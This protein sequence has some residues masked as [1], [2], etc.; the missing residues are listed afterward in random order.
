VVSGEKPSADFDF[1]LNAYCFSRIE[2]ERSKKGMVNLGQTVDEIVR[3]RSTVPE[4]R[5]LLVGISGIDGSGKGYV[6][7][8][9]EAR[10][11]QCAI[12][13]ANINVDGWLNLPE[14]RFDLRSLAQN[15]YE[16]AIRFDEFFTELVIPLRDRRSMHLT[17]NYA[18][19]TAKTY[20]QHI[21]DF[22]N[23]AVILVEGI[24]LFKRE[25]QKFFDLKIWIECS[26]STALARALARKQEGLAPADAIDAYQAIYFP[27]QRIHLDR[28]DP[29]TGADLILNND[30]HLNKHLWYAEHHGGNA[31]AQIVH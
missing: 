6:A 19:E 25:Y 31:R 24:F 12:A 3:R 20:C 22:R 29:R 18:E 10:L 1:D 26:F 4:G 7:K 21:Y 23:I 8:Q 14:T 27:A 9:L 13:V 15:F 2:V 30:P 17:A 11:G 28:D 16:R 5:G